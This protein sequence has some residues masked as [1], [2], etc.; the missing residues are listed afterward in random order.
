MKEKIL[1]STLIVF[2]RLPGLACA[3]FCVADFNAHKVFC[4]LSQ[5]FIS[6]CQ[7]N[8][9]FLF[10]LYIESSSEQLPNASPKLGI[11]SR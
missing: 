1:W 7:P 4:H 6:V 2:G 11:T 8:V 9:R 3:C 5:R 10:G